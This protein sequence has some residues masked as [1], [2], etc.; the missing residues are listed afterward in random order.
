VRALILAQFYSDPAQRQKLRELSGLGWSVTLAIPNGTA[1][2]DG[3]IRVAPVPASG[4]PA[5]PETLRWS[6]RALRRILSDIRPDLVHIEEEPGTQAADMAV[7]EA[8]RLGIPAV[9]FSWNSLPLDLGFFERRRY[10][11]TMAGVS[12][13]IGGNRMAQAILLEAAPNVPAAVIPQLGV[14][15]PGQM[16]LRTPGPLAMA[17]VGRLVPERGLDRLLRACGQLLGHWSLAIA[18]TGPEQELLE[19]LAQRL[20]L[21]ARTRW[22]GAMSRAQIAQFWREVDCLVVPSRST[23]DWVEQYSPVVL[24]AMA[25]GAAVVASSEGVLPELVGEAG[26]LFTTDEDLLVGLQELVADPERRL[27]MG[28]AGRKRVLDRFVDAAIARATADFWNTV[29]ATAPP[30]AVA[31]SA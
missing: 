31:A 17:F 9:I 10:Q 7:R 26:V 20:G 3:A 14:V 4:D 19:D 23:A 16:E 2:M 22:L 25:H 8:A 30:R 18:G 1:D 12:G 15:P 5:Q 29:L 13:V 24:D 11:R 28:Q 6:G 27:A 21:A